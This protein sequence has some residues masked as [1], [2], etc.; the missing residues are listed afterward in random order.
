MKRL[1]KWAFDYIIFGN[2]FIS[3]AAVSLTLE[4]YLMINKPLKVDGLL[5]FIFF[6]TLFEYNLHRHLSLSNSKAQSTP[7]KFNWALEN[8]L[9]FKTT[10]YGSLLG[11]MIS[12]C[13]IHLTIL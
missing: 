11:L 12:V 1:F 5:F 6:S 10:F 2:W 7:E 4:T 13:F 3:F 9:L 8:N